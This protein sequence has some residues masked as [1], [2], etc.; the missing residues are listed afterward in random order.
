MI[1]RRHDRAVVTTHFTSQSEAS[2][3]YG[4]PPLVLGHWVEEFLLTDYPTPWAFLNAVAQPFIKDRMRLTP[5]LYSIRSFVN[6]G[7]TITETT[8]MGFIDTDPE[9]ARIVGAIV[10][11]ELHYL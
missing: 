3:T 4:I 7:T 5:G 6:P 9:I 8:V 1:S 11:A 2:R 10:N